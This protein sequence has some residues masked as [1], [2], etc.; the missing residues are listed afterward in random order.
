MRIAILGNSVFYLISTVFLSDVILGASKNPKRISPNIILILADDLGYGDVDWHDRNLYT[1]NLRNLAFSDH[2]VQL[3]NSYVGQLCTPTRAALMTG[4]YPFHTGTQNGVFL[5]TEPSSVP[6]DYPFF[7][8]YLRKSGYRTYMVGKWHLG[9]C[10]RDYL[11][12]VRGGFDSFYGYYGPQTGYF[13]HSADLYDKNDGVFMRVFV[14]ERNQPSHNGAPTKDTSQTLLPLFSQYTRLCRLQIYCSMLAAMDEAVGRV[15]D[16]LKQTGLYKDTVIIF[17][18]DNG[19]DANFG[20]S[21][22]PLRGSKN[23]LWEGGTKTTTLVHYPRM[24]HQF[25]ERH[26]LFHVVDWRTQF[27]YNID[28]PTSA[29]RR[30][31]YKLI[32]ESPIPVISEGHG[33]TRLF[34]LSSDPLEQR[35]LS[36][37]HPAL[38]RQLVDKLITYQH[39]ARKSVR[40]ALD[41]RGNPALLNG[42]YASYWC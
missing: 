13:N 10:R 15:V 25:A 5:Q 32:Y 29:I 42:A 19:G 14:C 12:T 40:N 38:V 34:D 22:A 18:S 16:H 27:V 9:Y 2:S 24:I 33:R 26:D 1:P 8:Q 21:N 3:S 30:Y 28:T 23:T 4:L 31:N 11:P 7:P 17:S 6:L 37:Q 41:P 35:D 20:A 39:H 36:R